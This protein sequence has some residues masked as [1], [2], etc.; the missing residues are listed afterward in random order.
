MREGGE[1][2]DKRERERKG[3]RGEKGRKGGRD[4]GRL[5]GRKCKTKAIESANTPKLKSGVLFHMSCHRK[6]VTKCPSSRHKAC[7]GASHSAV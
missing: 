2:R 3:R 7:K 5:V 1:Q 6:E 4:V